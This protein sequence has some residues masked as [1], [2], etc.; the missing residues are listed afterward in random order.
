[1][2]IATNSRTKTGQDDNHRPMGCGIRG[3]QFEFGR[4]RAR[5]HSA[6][7]RETIPLDPAIAADIIQ[8]LA[9]C[10]QKNEESGVSWSRNGLHPG[11]FRLRRRQSLPRWKREC[12]GRRIQGQVWVVCRV[13]IE[14]VTPTRPHEADFALEP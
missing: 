9:N 8:Y 12:E 5:W 3:F 14:R 4:A 11:S 2:K 7:S 13:R 6:H 10:N 1:M